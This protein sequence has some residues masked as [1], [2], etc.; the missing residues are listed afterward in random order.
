MS[1]PLKDVCEFIVDC[2]HSTAPDE[3]EGYP[4]IRTPNIGPGY[5]DLT[6]VHRVSKAV[7]DERNARAVPRPMDLILAREAPAG[8]VGI[9]LDGQQVCLGQRTV[10]IRPDQKKVDPQ[11]LNYYLNAPRQR[12]RLLSNAN[13]A[14]VSHVNMPVIRALPVDLPERRQ[15]ERVAEILGAYDKLIESNRKQ[16]A[17]L[18]E[19]AQRLYKEWFVNLRFPGHENTK[20]V[21]GLPEGW[22]YEAISKYCDVV[23][24]CSYKS[25]EID[26]TNGIPMVTLASIKSFGGFKPFLERVYT[27]KH[28]DSQILVKNDVLM[29]LTEQAAGLAGYVARVPRYAQGFLPSMDLVVLRPKSG[30]SSYLYSACV[31]GQVS[32]ELSPL[33]NGTKIKHLKPEVFDYIKMLVPPDVVQEQF[34]VELSNIFALQD[35]LLEQTNKARDARN[36]L[37]PKLMSGEIEV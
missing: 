2:P 25:T 11:F 31:F 19:A 32:R 18:E 30:A 28:S 10:L 23:K 7:Y 37:L 8:N 6:D 33:A 34:D 27:G 36:R 20:I 5:L 12:H 4:L 24:G 17:L 26:A 22:R 35:S 9:V 14:T 1:V 16:I 29:A 15:Q 13:G 3:G 21:N